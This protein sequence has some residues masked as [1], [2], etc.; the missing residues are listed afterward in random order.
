[1]REI[2]TLSMFGIPSI[3]VAANVRPAEPDV[4]I[5]SAYVGDWRIREINE[6]PCRGNIKKLQHKIACNAKELDRL[7]AAVLEAWVEREY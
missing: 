3:T 6:K 5:M 7:C 1:M 4:G 2:V